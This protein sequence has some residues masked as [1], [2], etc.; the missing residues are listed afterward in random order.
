VKTV[1]AQTLAVT[2]VRSEPASDILLKLVSDVLKQRF[3]TFSV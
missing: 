1:K 3:L 2:D